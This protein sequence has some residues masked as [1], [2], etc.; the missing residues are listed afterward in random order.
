M[1]MGKYAAE[2]RDST[3]N[4]IRV[5]LGTFNTGE[6]AL[7]YDQAAL[8]MRVRVLANLDGSVGRILKRTELDMEFIQCDINNL[9]WRGQIVETV[10][11]NPSF[12]TQRKGHMFLP[13]NNAHVGGWIYRWKKYA[14]HDAEQTCYK[15]DNPH[16]FPQIATMVSTRVNFLP[17]E[18]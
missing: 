13:P 12:G 3:R 14:N 18:F 7:A 2:I 6:E 16:G 9:T 8:T 5:W 17:L 15:L 10:V 4:G 11:M 1:T